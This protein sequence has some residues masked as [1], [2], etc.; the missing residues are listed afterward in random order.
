MLF[1]AGSGRHALQRVAQGSVS[2][3]GGDRTR[4]QQLRQP[5]RAGRELT[6]SLDEMRSRFRRGRKDADGRRKFDPDEDNPLLEE[7][8]S[9][10]SP[11]RPDASSA[12]PA[13]AS[14]V[15]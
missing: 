3:G 6:R 13:A 5:R 14:A 8:R 2:L 11:R 1:K 7:R 12:F 15:G 4:R 10:S 9:T